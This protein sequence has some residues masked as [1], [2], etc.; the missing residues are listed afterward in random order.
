MTQPVYGN[1]SANNNPRALIIF[2]VSHQAIERQGY[3]IRAVANP[4]QEK[5]SYHYEN[6]SSVHFRSS[7][8]KSLAIFRTSTPGLQCCSAYSPTRVSPPPKYLSFGDAATPSI[9]YR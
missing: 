7:S 5:H 2:R 6:N 9:T 1:E 3:I 8:K 4:R